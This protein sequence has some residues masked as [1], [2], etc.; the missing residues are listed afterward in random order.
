[1]TFSVGEPTIIASLYPPN[2]P[3]EGGW[4]LIPPLTWLLLIPL[5]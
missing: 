3:Y 2:P 5:F 1:M 4:F